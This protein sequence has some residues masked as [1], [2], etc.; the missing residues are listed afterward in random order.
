MW[1][2]RS[3]LPG[4]FVFEDLKMKKKL[5]KN[6]KADGSGY[7]IGRVRGLRKESAPSSVLR[8]TPTNFL[9]KFVLSIMTLFL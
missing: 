4:P 6:C 8:K 9:L 3:E 1:Q 5:K 2:D 7:P